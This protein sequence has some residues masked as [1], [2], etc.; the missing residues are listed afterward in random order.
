ML[1]A[2]GEARL[3][4]RLDGQGFGHV[5]RSLLA[6]PELHLSKQVL[7]SSFISDEP[8]AH[9]TRNFI[10][11]N[12]FAR[13]YSPAMSHWLISPPECCSIRLLNPEPKPKK[14]P[15]FQAGLSLAGGEGFEP[16]NASTK[17]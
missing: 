5:P 12:K 9:L 1:M 15:P 3:S 13:V 11:A 10:I 4:F 8:Q 16:P 2:G 7:K 14:N 17:N 6:T